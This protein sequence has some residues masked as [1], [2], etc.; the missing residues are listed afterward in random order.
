MLPLCVSITPLGLPVDPL[1]YIK[2]EISF[3]LLLI[4]KFYIV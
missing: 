4:L 2:K 3:G 1:V